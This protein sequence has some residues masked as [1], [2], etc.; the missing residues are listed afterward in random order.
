MEFLHMLR[1]ILS[2]FFVF[3]LAPMLLFGQEK[4]LAL[5]NVHEEMQKLF[6]EHLTQKK[7]TAEIMERAIW[8]F[9]NQF[10]PLHVYLLESEVTPYLTLSKRQLSALA[11][12]AD[13]EDYDIF[14]KINT[15][16]Q[17]SIRK[18]RL[19]RRT[20]VVDIEVFNKFSKEALPLIEPGKQN[21]PSSFAENEVV[22][23]RLQSIYMAHLVGRELESFKQLNKS[24]TFIEAVRNVELELEEFENGY[25]YLNKAGKPLEEAQ[26]NS[27]FAL[28][29]LKAF[30]ASL[31]VHSEFFNTKEAEALRM[32]LQKEYEGVGVLIEQGGDSFYVSSVVKGSSA[33]LSGKVEVGD[34]LISIDQTKTKALTLVEVEEMLSGKVGTYIDLGFKRDNQKPFHVVLERRHTIL[35]EGRVDTTFEQVPGGVVGVIQLHAFYQGQGDVS[36]EQDVLNA[37][38]ALSKQ[39]EIKGL[40]L[41]LR[42]NRGGFLLQ[43]VKVAGL[44]IKTGVIVAAKYSDGTLRYFRDTDPHVAY[45]GPL[46]ILTSRETASAAE[47]VA[48]ALKDYGVAIIVG[49]LQTYGKG[50]IQ[51]ETV[52]GEKDSDVGLKVTIGRYYSVS[53]SSTQLQGVKSDIVVPGTFEK[54]NVGE[55]FLPETIK[56]DTIG[57]SFHDTLQDVSEKEKGWYEKYYIPFLQ[58]KTDTYRKWIPDLARKSKDRLAKN[59]NYQNLLRGENFITE[60]H[61]LTEQ[62]IILEPRSRERT[63]QNMQLQEAIN[64]TKDLIQDVASQK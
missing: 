3:F 44:F 34:E 12:L 24:L 5:Q 51:T 47:I 23:Q 17:E 53:G 6:S 32:K 62:K 46:I 61:G 59:K 40:V 16:I 54:R 41:D 21:E 19:F 37:L 8:H 42:D 52:T 1:R 48:E 26:V 64:I 38:K 63:L 18:L 29:I 28:H 50:S 20:M 7:M 39:G 35:Q 57:S 13:K 58:Q 43:A 25:L 15:T 56:A 4:E 14:K 11:A 36:S 60:M 27:L 30:T 31:D 9:I 49:D 10:D 2:F 55:S 22:L 33:G 45:S